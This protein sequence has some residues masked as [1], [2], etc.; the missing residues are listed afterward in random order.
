[1]VI[2]AAL[3]PHTFGADSAPADVNSRD[4]LG[5]A[6]PPY[7]SLQSSTLFNSSYY[8]AI[9]STSFYLLYSQG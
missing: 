7:F 2:F 5:P 4:I 9:T 8:L 6:V 3:F 1:M